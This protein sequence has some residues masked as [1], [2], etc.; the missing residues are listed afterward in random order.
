MRQ[1]RLMQ[2]LGWK[3]CWLILLPQL[4]VTIFLMIFLRGRLDVLD[5]A[6]G[7]L[8]TILPSVFFA[9]RCQLYAT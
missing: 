8:A 3:A 2:L 1:R 6:Y 5:L 9:W 7:A 4:I